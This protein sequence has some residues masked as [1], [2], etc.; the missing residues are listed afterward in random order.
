MT[1]ARIA[2][3]LARLPEGVTELC[4]HI[5][6]RPWPGPDAWPAEFAC[7]AEYEALVDPGIAQLIARRDIARGAFR[8]LEP[9][10]RAA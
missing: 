1:G 8:D 3:C 7:V 2:A 4:L 5:A 10:R 6:A 9:A